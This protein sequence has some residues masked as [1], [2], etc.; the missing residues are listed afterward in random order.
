MATL[1]RDGGDLVITLA[2]SER[3]EAMGLNAE[4]RLPMSAVRKVEVVEDPI[5][6]I[7]GLRPRN[8]KITGTYVPGKTAVGTF[9]DGSLSKRLFA[10]VHDNQRRGVRISLDEAVHF[11][12]IILSLDDPEDVV[13]RVWVPEERT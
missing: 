5:H 4:I 2:T 9:L 10:A 11:N 13:A 8:F 6:E 1:I 3:I 7:H 12:D